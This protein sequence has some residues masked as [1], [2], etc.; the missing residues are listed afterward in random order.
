MS[1][2]SLFVYVD[3]ALVSVGIIA[4]TFL[5][6]LVKYDILRLLPLL[7]S[8]QYPLFIFSWCYAKTFLEIFGEVRIIIVAIFSHTGMKI[9]LGIKEESKPGQVKSG[10]GIQLFGRHA[11]KL[12]TNSLLQSLIPLLHTRCWTRYLI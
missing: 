10:H 11:D 6:R 9:H 12:R 3:L 7:E 1:D 2:S 5:I 8:T 4:L